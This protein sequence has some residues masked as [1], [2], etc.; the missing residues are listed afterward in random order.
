MYGPHAWH[1]FAV[2]WRAGTLGVV[3]DAARTPRHAA[4]LSAEQLAARQHTPLIASVDELAA[5][6]W[7]DDDEVDAFLADVRRARQANL[8]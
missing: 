1:A 5:D 8:A 3:S 2:S 6:I 7:L 4:P